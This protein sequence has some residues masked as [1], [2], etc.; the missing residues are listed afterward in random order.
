[1]FRRILVAFDGSEQ[2]KRAF[3]RAIDLAACFNSELYGLTV[4]EDAPPS[5]SVPGYGPAESEEP[6]RSAEMAD[7]DRM[8]YLDEAPARALAKG[9]RIE[10]M[11]AEGE[12]ADAIIAA[13]NDLKCDLLVFG[14]RRH[15]GLFDSLLS[16]TASTLE[17]QSPCSIV[18]VR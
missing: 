15:R 9:V 6:V 16:H 14:L 8:S 13:V 5:V 10:L 12:A 4:F 17:E 3:D 11:S 18:G 7:L 2:S 1:M